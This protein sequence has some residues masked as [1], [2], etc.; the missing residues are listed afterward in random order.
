MDWSAFTT[1]L[2]TSLGGTGILIAIIVFFSKKWLGSRIE[3]SVKHE[4]AKKL[5]EHKA[6]LHEQL[7][8]SVEQMKAVFQDAVD[9][10]ATDK[11]LFAKFMDTLPSS[12][13]IE[14][15]KTFD[16][17]FGS[18]DTDQLSQLKDFYYSWNNPEYEFLNTDL[19]SKRRELGNVVDE[20]FVSYG[21]NTFLRNDCLDQKR[22]YV[23][24]EWKET[25]PENYR[26]AV[27]ELNSLADKVVKA[28]EDLVRNARMRLIC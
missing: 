2:L 6:Q 16:M 12:G 11:A 4:Y 9:L 1:A 8:L 25:H 20:Y 15:L 7:N 3:E 10:K 17:G 13:S 27:D 21:K 23:P 5:E 22:A 28:H 24:T 14:F 18:F 26:Q 19:E